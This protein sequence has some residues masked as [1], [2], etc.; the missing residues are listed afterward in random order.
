MTDP[1][2]CPFY[3]VSS[4]PSL[5]EVGEASLT[6]MGGSA[7]AP[8]LSFDEFGASARCAMSMVVVDAPVL[9]G[10]SSG[11]PTTTLGEVDDQ[12]CAGSYS[13]ESAMTSGETDVSSFAGISSDELA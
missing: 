11:E 2:K 3:L 7:Q 6:G 12:P 9:V 13:D 5:F 10:S 1:L 8:V 4:G